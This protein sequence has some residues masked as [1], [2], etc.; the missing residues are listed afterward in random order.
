MW[1]RFS[2][3]RRD[4]FPSL[5]VFPSIPPNEECKTLHS[6]RLNGHS[7]IDYQW[8]LRG[9]IYGKGVVWDLFIGLFKKYFFKSVWDLPKIYNI[10]STNRLLSDLG[11]SS[12]FSLANFWVIEKLYPRYTFSIST[13]HGS[14]ISLVQKIWVMA[15]TNGKLLVKK[16]L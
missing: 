10:K 14:T 7:L 2:G 5:S 4:C 3:W 8:S 16:F 13:I 12:T 15:I 9:K 11:S 1:T 6:L